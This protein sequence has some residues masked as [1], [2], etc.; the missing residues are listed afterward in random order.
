MYK[1]VTKT[2]KK[3]NA[4]ATNNFF[5]ITTRIYLEQKTEKSKKYALW[6]NLYMLVSREIWRDSKTVD[7]TCGWQWVSYGLSDQILSLNEALR[8]SDRLLSSNEVSM[9]NRKYFWIKHERI[10]HVNT[11]SFKWESLRKHAHLI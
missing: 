2:R 9:I 3:Q 7:P 4:R 10:K 1:T 6:L 11:W 5:M 8:L